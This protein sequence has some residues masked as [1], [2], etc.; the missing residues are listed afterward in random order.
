MSKLTL[1]KAQLK[2]IQS[3]VKALNDVRQELQ[4]ENIDFNINWYL[5]D[6]EN[7]FLMECESHDADGNPMQDGV[8]EVF[9]LRMASGGGW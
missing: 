2:K 1:T 7:L 8:I 4:D 3:A 5:E 9:R 6:S